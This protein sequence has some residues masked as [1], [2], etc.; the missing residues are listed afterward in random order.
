VKF[1]FFKK[2]E[3]TPLSVRLIGET[4]IGLKRSQNQD[5]YI[6][7]IGDHSGQGY[8]AL[9]IVADGMGGHVMGDV[10]S[11]MAIEVIT[12]Q[13][14]ELFE[15]A[16]EL[17]IDCAGLLTQSV[18]KANEAIYS[19]D[20][21][22]NQKP[23]GTTCSAAL[24]SNNRL[25]ISHAGDSRVYLFRN[26][27]LT[28]LTK[29]DSWVMEQVDLGNLTPCQAKK[30][31]NRNIITQALG[32]QQVVDIEEL[33]LDL[34]PDDRILLSSDGLHGLLDVNEIADILTTPI[35][36]VAVENLINQAKVYGGDD[37]ITVVIADMTY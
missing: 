2:R 1:P 11:H 18:I 35:L 34:K 13:L 5:A 36:E 33:T 10:A 3:S 23:M 26:R 22:S 14:K 4:D 20:S 28:Q 29:D 7:V 19:E 32:I 17:K 27:K 21:I 8:D 24:F 6:A 25:Y 30:H 12:S 16:T 15:I 37:N 9:A 31:P